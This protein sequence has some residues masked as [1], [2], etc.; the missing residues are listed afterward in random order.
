MEIDERD[1][2]CSFKTT[3]S[4]YYIF[5]SVNFYFLYQCHFIIFS[6]VNIFPFLKFLGYK[7]LKI[8]VLIL[9]IDKS[10]SVM[11]NSYRVNSTQ[12][13]WTLYY[14]IVYCIIVYEHELY[15]VILQ[16]KSIWNIFIK[17]PCVN[18]SSLNHST[19]PKKYNNNITMF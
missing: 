3:S 19:F 18:V 1:G 17:F 10:A 13:Y 5:V 6:W 2:E 11:L 9:S 7:I 4:L 14:W 15:T 8:F 16:I 12:Y